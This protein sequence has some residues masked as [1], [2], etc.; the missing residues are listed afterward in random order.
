M[1]VE[2]VRF[3][4]IEGDRKGDIMSICQERHLALEW[5]CSD[6]GWDDARADT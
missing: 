5:I 2:G 3:I 4:D 6:V 1:L